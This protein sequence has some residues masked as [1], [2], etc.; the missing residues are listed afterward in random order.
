MPQRVNNP[1][2]WR[3]YAEETRKIADQ[4]K[5]PESKRLLMGVAKTYAEL[6]RR[7]IAAEA[8]QPLKDASE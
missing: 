2:Y 5:D 7:A 1:R 3:S 6:A 4:I 8:S